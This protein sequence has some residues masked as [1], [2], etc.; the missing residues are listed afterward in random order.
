LNII[1]K[2]VMKGA[3]TL[4]GAGGQVLGCQGKKAGAAGRGPT[5]APVTAGEISD[6][7]AVVAL[8]FGY[9]I[10]SPLIASWKRGGF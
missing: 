1:A 9:F 10:S 6:A 2:V 7:E 5:T 3:S 8:F 4:F